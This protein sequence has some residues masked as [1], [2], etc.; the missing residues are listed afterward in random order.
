MPFKR[1]SVEFKV[2]LGYGWL[3]I[4]SSDLRGMGLILIIEALILKRLT[5]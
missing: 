4:G 2:G 1:E 5:A 3:F